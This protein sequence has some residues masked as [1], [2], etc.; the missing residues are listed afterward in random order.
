MSGILAGLTEF[1]QPQFWIA[2]VEIIWINILLS[3]DNAIVIALGLPQPAAEA[4]L[5]A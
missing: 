2:V 1:S 4:R 5:G 3:G